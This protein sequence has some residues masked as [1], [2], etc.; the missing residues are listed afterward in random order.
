MDPS[1]QAPLPSAF[2]LGLAKAEPQEHRKAER[3][4]R[5][6]LPHSARSL[7]SRAVWHWLV[8]SGGS[9][10]L[11]LPSPGSGDCSFLGLSKLLQ[12]RGTGVEMTS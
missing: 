12:G 9:S 7:L 2:L 1:T 6:C 10:T 4:G 5:V 11:A 8:L 3:S